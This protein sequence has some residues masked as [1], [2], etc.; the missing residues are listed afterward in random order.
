MAG[1]E[2]YRYAAPAGRVGRS[3]LHDAGLTV[4]DVD[5]FLFHQANLRIIESVQNAVGIPAGK[6]YLNIETYG[7]TRRLG[8]DGARGGGRRRAHQPGD[9]I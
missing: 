6:T 1:K 4:D 2:V 9:R 3:A 5:Q 8:P 7:N